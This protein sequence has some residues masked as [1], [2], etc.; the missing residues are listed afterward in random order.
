MRSGVRSPSAPPSQ[1]T[2]LGT[3]R[4]FFAF[5]KQRPGF[6]TMTVNSCSKEKDDDPTIAKCNYST[7]VLSI[8]QHIGSRLAAMARAG[9]E[10]D[11]AGERSPQRVAEGRT[12]TALAGK[13]H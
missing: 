9:E 13:R 4:S 5:S 8:R 12:K 11:L 6:N 7:L 10:W 1:A 3:L 2:L